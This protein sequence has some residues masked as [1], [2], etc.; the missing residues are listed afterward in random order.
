MTGSRFTKLLDLAREKDSER[1]RQLLHDVTDLF[2]ETRGARTATADDLFGDILQSVAK[3]MQDGV[4]VE[5]AERFA[6][7]DDAP[8]G[9]MTDLAN[10]AFEVAAPVLRASPVLDDAVLVDIVQHRSQQHIKAVAQ[11]PSVSESVSDA[12]VRKGDDHA[13]DALMRNDGAKLSRESMEAAVER[14]RRN[15]MLHEGVVKRRDMP[16]D[17]INEM[18]FLVEQR[19]RQQILDRNASVDRDTLDQALARTRERL[20]KAAGEPTDEL[21]RANVFI[22]LKKSEGEL[23]GKL[24]IS[25]FRDKQHARFLCGLAELTGIDVDTARQIIE[26][27]DIDALAM[28]C[29][30]SD[31][32]RPLFVTMA[33]LC[34]SNAGEDG[35]ARGEE[36]GRLYNSVPVEAAQRAMRFYR[37]RKSTDDKA[38]A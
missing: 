16:L 13:L 5:L 17:L 8:V 34:G 33:V 6:D 30:A 9:L 14:A 18:Y 3:E 29:R 2:F 20:R 11:R 27:R 15:V 38:A 23:N 7:A 21:R 22:R 26:A 37:V 10:H 32:E 35:M 25:L 4:L 1:R 31:I 28:I 19:L 24:L 36:F 12:I